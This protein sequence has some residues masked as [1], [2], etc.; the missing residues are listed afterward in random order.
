VT[1]A[2]PEELL[3]LR[4]IARWMREAGLPYARQRVERLV[5]TEG[6]LRVYAG[7]ADGTESLMALER[8]TGV[9]HNDIRRWL[10]AWEAEGIAEPGAKPPKARFS[11]AELGIAP[12]PAKPRRTGKG[13]VK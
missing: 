5:D 7:M 2:V 4:E 9:N 3:L 6:K 10:D 8:T 13:G 11:I 1:D 12:P